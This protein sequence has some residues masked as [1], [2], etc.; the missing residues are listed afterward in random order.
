VV[1]H[2]PRQCGKTTLARTFGDSAGFAYFTLD[3]AALLQAA[4]SDPV[5]F[6]LDLPEHATIDEA[7]RVPALV[8][9]LK[10]A[11]DRDRRPGRFIL[12]GS[13]NLLFVPGLADAL[14]GR[15]EVL[16]LHPLA[17][18]ELARA[19]SAFVDTLFSAALR[20]GSWERLGPELA[21]RVAAGGYPAALQRGS[22]L[23]RA[24]WYSEYVAALLERDIRDLA[25]VGAR[26]AMFRMLQLAAQRSGLIRNVTDVA[27]ACGVSRPTATDYEGLLER[28]FLVH[29]LP[30]WHLNRMS[31]LVKAPKLHVADTGV[32]CALLGMTAQGLEADRSVL[33]PLV[34][35][36][37]LQELR[38]QAGWS[39]EPT[40][41]HHFRTRD[42]KEVDIVME[43]GRR[44]VGVEA[45]A[46]ST[47][48][49]SDFGALR[50]LR[51]GAGDRFVC[52]VV[53]YDGETSVGF[54]DRLYAA[55]IRAMWEPQAV[56]LPSAVC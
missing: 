13:A 45:K 23:R 51:D 53:L 4:R 37:V 28:L 25:R 17:Q 9:S 47:V 20:I 50:L 34:E 49:H 44:V 8:R 26:D 55:P 35:A 10:A 40:S 43:R 12:T 29:V 15:M 22:A 11:V 46:G 6:V 52:G 30:A 24:A 33:G 21:R 14:V 2:G 42:G 54:G 39:G 5:G 3:D 16:Q 1:I 18:A 41:F 56:P 38:R 27:A 7:Q 32:A 36:F 19:P 31:R 48:T